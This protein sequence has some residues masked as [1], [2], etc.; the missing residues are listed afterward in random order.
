MV[1][2][3]ADPTGIGGQIVDPIGHRTAQFLDQEVMHPDLFGLAVRAPLPPGVLE[4]PHQF[5]LLRVHRDHRL[6]LGQ[7]M[8]DARADMGELRVAVRMAVALAGLAVSLEAELLPLEQLADHRVADLV[9]TGAQFGGQPAKALAGPTQRRHRV[10]PFT[11]TDKRQQI[12]Q[13]RRVRRHQQ[14]ASAPMP[15]NATARQPRPA[16]EFLQASADRA[17]SDPGGTRHGG[18]AAT[19][20]RPRLAGGE[21]STPALVKQRRQSNKTG[22]DGGGIDHSNTL[23][24]LHVTGE[25]PSSQSYTNPG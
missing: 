6:P 24:N 17:D 22:I 9:P 13:Q 15:A 2:A 16:V 14:L 5:L 4:V 1:H 18:N 25:S 10:A 12:V 20:G 19:P 11:R 7:R 21:R 23:R 8:R 3:H